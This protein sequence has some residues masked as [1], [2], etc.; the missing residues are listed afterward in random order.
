MVVGVLPQ[1]FLFKDEDRQEKFEPTTEGV[2]R[3]EQIAPPA[4]SRP[5]RRSSKLPPRVV[6]PERRMFEPIFIELR[7]GKVDRKA[8]LQQSAPPARSRSPRRSAGERNR[9]VDARIFSI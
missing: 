6:A 4:R 7:S 5:P 2:A 1:P 9:T 3:R 8:K